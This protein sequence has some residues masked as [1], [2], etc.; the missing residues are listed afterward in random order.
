MLIPLYLY[1]RKLLHAPTFYLSEYLEANHQE[2]YDRLLAVSSRDDWT[3]WCE[4][5]LQALERQAR[6]NEAKTRR[7]LTLYE[8]K[9]GW[10]VKTTHSQYAIVALDFLFSQPVF[11]SSHFVSEA[12]IPAP[13]ARRI[14]K[15]CRAKGLLKPIREASGQRPAV[16][17]FPELVNIAEGRSVF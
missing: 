7:V 9:K 10:M 2:Y 16:F 15:L 14:L 1:E 8:E 17:A 4:F 11:S 13:T 12:H 3:G 5:F 6:E